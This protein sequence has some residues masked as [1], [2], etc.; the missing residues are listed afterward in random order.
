MVGNSLAYHNFEF[1]Q[2]GVYDL[3]IKWNIQELARK[4]PPLQSLH[5]ND[6]KFLDSKPKPGGGKHYLSRQP[7]SDMKLSVRVL[8]QQQSNMVWIHQIGQFISKFGQQF[9]KE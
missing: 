8:R 3:W 7:Y 9:T 6:Y 5:L 4:I 1:L 2:G